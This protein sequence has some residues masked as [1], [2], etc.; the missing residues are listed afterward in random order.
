MSDKFTGY[1]L[2]AAREKARAKE[3]ERIARHFEAMGV[4]DY[5]LPQE[6]ADSIRSL[7]KWGT[8]DND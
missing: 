1:W 6:I 7:D 4:H 3:R 8:K 2:E 5:W